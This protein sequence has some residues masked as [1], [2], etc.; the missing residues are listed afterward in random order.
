MKNH[1]KIFW[2]ISFH[3]KIWLVG[4][5]LVSFGLKFKRIRLGI[6]IGIYSRIGFLTGQKSVITLVISHSNAKIWFIWF[7]AFRKNINFACYNTY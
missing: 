6:D 3:K 5:Y 2:L 7:F 1:T 4:R